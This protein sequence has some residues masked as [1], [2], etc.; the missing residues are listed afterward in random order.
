MALLRKTC[1]KQ[2]IVLGMGPLGW[3]WCTEVS[4]RSHLELGTL[5]NAGGG[6]EAQVLCHGTWG[7]VRKTHVFSGQSMKLLELM[8]LRDGKNQVVFLREVKM[9]LQAVELGEGGTRKGCPGEG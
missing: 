9:D 5:S 6:W 4:H 8:P 7:L 2:R 1:P 3:Q